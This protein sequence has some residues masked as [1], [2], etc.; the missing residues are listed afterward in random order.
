MQEV[1]DMISRIRQ[2]R[3][4]LCLKWYEFVV[5]S[6]QRALFHSLYHLNQLR[7]TIK[8]EILRMDDELAD[9]AEYRRRVKGERHI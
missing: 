9:C 4:L 2:A 1:I 8:G 7:N 6:I 5:S 3:D